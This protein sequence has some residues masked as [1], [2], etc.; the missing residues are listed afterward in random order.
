MSRNISDTT[1]Q[2]DALDGLRGFAA[3]IVI[4]SHTS[5]AAMYFFPFLDARGIGK[6]GVFLFFLLSSFLLSR[7]LIKKGNDAFSKKAISQYAQR[8]FFRIYPLY[9]PYLLLGLVST[10]IFNSLLNKGIGIPFSL[11]VQ[12]FLSH[13]F[14]LDGKGV[15]WSIAVEFKFYF[16]LPM[17]LFIAYHIRNKFN[18]LAEL[19]FLICLILLTQVVSPQSESL[20]NDSR[21]LPYMCI[22]LLG[23]IL[24]VVQCQIDSGRIRKQKLKA[25]IPLSYLS[26]L[27]L[28]FLTPTGASLV[29]GEVEKN[30][31]HKDFIQYA[32][33]WGVV[34]LSIINFNTKISSLFKMKWLCFYGA[35]SFSIYLFHPIFI[36]IAKKILLNNY[37]SA[38]FVL[39]TST[40]AAYIS[41]KLLEMPASKFKIPYKSGS[42]E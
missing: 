23:T 33:L 14:L 15:T 39:I 16:V 38:W 27:I 13:L 22:F 25:I 5:N 21:L 18:T 42:R 1:L 28:T 30:Y 37:L 35:L 34:L 12:E 24:A 10:F 29:L 4:F 7:A 17:V 26:I 9:I 8:R 6:S 2:L 11:T 36:T 3:L 19:C 40:I 20:V 31:F 32:V 41:F